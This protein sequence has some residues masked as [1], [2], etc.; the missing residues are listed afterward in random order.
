MCIRDRS[1][2]RYPPIGTRWEV[3]RPQATLAEQQSQ[4]TAVSEGGCD[5]IFSFNRTRR[6]LIDPPARLV[7]A[8]SEGVLEFEADDVVE[9][10]S[11]RTLVRA[12]NGTWY[13]PVD[14]TLPLKRGL[15]G[16][17][18]VSAALD[19]LQSRQLMEAFYL[20]TVE[21]V[22]EPLVRRA[23][24]LIMFRYMVE[25]GYTARWLGTYKQ[26]GHH[27]GNGH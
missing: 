23:L 12:T 8:L 25:R 1:T 10:L 19:K 13:N 17:R 22:Q 24:G 11:P 27:V 20:L 7:K 3:S 21:K 15:L 26:A 14:T 16:K 9:G 4:P 18:K 5:G 2:K 6:V